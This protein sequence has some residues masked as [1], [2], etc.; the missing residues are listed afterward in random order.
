M[1]K[2][3]FSILALPLGA[4][5]NTAW[6]PIPLS[7]YKRARAWVS[8]LGSSQAAP[9]A[10]GNQTRFSLRR[11]RAGRTNGAGK[12]PRGGAVRGGAELV[13]RWSRAGPSG[14]TSGERVSGSQVA[15]WCRCV[16]TPQLLHRARLG[17]GLGI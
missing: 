13:P 5:G 6:H 15:A 2:N 12:P 4:P 11:P 7:H 16:K 10:G 1:A 14:P 8:W 3:G 9:R 17:F